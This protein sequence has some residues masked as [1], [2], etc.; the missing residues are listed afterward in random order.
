MIEDVENVHHQNKELVDSLHDWIITTPKHLRSNVWK[1]FGLNTID[2]K[3]TNKD[4]AVFRLCKKKKK[5][6]AELLYNDNKSEHSAAC[7]NPSKG[8]EQH[9]LYNFV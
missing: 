2:G 3:I 7:C 5:K 4:Q 8:V 1:Y 6:T 9:Q